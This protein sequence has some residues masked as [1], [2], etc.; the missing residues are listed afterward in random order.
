MSAKVLGHGRIEVGVI[1]WDATTNNNKKHK[2]VVWHGL[3]HKNNRTKTPPVSGQFRLQQSLHSARLYVKLIG[4]G[5]IK[6]E[7]LSLT[8][9]LLPNETPSAAYEPAH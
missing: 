4:P 2:R 3:L 7:A 6:V 8:R 5:E 9:L 1:G